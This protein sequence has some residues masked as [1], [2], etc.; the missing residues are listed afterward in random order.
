MKTKYYIVIGIISII[1][2]FLIQRFL[3]WKVSAIVFQLILYVV[4]SMVTTFVVRRRLN[5][6]GG[7]R[8]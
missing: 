2:G 6:K 8:V 3:D 5:Q 7:N 4:I 1:L